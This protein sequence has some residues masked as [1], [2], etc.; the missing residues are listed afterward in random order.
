M[1]G[2]NNQQA[3]T[4]YDTALRLLAR[5]EHSRRELHTKLQLRDYEKQHI[6]QALDRLCEQ[7]YLS[8]RRFAAA[9]VDERVAKGFGA[10]RI[11]AELR[12]RGIDG[13]LIDAALMP[14]AGQWD[15]LLAHLL[16]RKFGDEAPAD[17]RQ[18]LKRARYLQ[19]RGLRADSIK[20]LLGDYE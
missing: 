19:T 15:T 10:L 14:F 3:A 8:D 16:Q 11:D 17:R 9:Y 20:R 5:R 2:R 13:E 4:A 6:E 7:N 12:E 1:N 18:W